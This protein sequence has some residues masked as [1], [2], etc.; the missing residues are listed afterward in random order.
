MSKS[1]TS[2]P[3]PED[4]PRITA[5]MLSARYGE[6]LIDVYSNDGFCLSQTLPYT[7]HY[8]EAVSYHSRSIVRLVAL[9][10]P[11][12]TPSN[13]R[14]IAALRTGHRQNAHESCSKTPH[15]VPQSCPPDCRMHNAVVSPARNPP[16]SPNCRN[17]TKNPT[18]W[19]SQKSMPSNLGKRNRHIYHASYSL[20]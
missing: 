15:F 1:G 20:M 8:L 17:L 18:D 12:T 4:G 2:V 11:P 9:K 13:S 5:W 10:P 7:G 19:D 16:L 14:K 3:P 6:P